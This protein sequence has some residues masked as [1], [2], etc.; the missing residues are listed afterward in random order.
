M[1]DLVIDISLDD[2]PTGMKNIIYNKLENASDNF[3]HENR[4]FILIYDDLWWFMMYLYP[5]NHYPLVN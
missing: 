5:M 1:G 4:W 2:F 3:A